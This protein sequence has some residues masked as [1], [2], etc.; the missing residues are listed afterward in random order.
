MWTANVADNWQIKM[1]YF[2]GLATYFTEQTYV[3]VS[4]VIL[5]YNKPFM[6]VITKVIY[7]GW[8]IQ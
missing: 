8:D 7:N 2:N 1:F 6:G 3:R 4:K 5:K